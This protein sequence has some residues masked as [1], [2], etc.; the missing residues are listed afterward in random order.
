MICLTQ[1]YAGGNTIKRDVPTID[2]TSMEAVLYCIK[3]FQETANELEY[4]TGG[5]L[6]SSFRRILRGAAK[7][8]W[9]IVI[10]Q[11]EDRNDITFALSLERWKSEM[12]YQGLVKYWWT[13]WNKLPS[14]VK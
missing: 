1:R 12:I 10:S 13:I 6:F 9:D 8:D 3:E 14:H 4:T 11:I 5:E 7:D 2:G